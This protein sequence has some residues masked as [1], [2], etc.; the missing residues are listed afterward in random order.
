MTVQS[1]NI[2]FDINH[3]GHYS[4]WEISEVLKD[5]Y[6]IPGNLLVEAL[7]HIPFIA[8]PLSI[9][10]SQA[11]GYSSLNGTLA[12][13]VSLVFWMLLLFTAL[14]KASPT[15]STDTESQ[16]PDAQTANDNGL[17]ET[18]QHLVTGTVAPSGLKWPRTLGAAS[19][20]SGHL[21]HRFAS[22][23]LGLSHKTEARHT[24]QAHAGPDSAHDTAMNA[25]RHRGR[26]AT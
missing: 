24:A 3:D 10:A 2:V 1:L 5:L 4:A 11:A 9:H 22:R 18:G 21:L 23:A 6:H 17:S 19:H 26:H 15:E 25:H 20:K 12:V 7:G 8:E 13:L 14:S 16:Y